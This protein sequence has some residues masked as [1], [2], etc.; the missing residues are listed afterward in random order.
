MIG[1]IASYNAW[2]NA[3]PD[4]PAGTIVHNNPDQPV[5]HP[6]LGQYEY[7]LRGSAFSALNLS[8]R[9]TIFSASWTSL[10]VWRATL[11]AA[12]DAWWSRRAAVS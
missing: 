9:C 1:M 11:G 3:H 8:T 10:R 12:F 7:E 6:P 2:V 5:A 4:L